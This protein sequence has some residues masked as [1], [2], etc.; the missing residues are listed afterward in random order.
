MSKA[1][2]EFRTR[3]GTD[4]REFAVWYANEDVQ[5]LIWQIYQNI[6]ADKKRH[7]LKP[8]VF[9]DN[10]EKNKDTTLDKLL[11]ACHH[12]LREHNLKFLPF[13]VKPKIL[14]HFYAGFIHINPDYIY[15]FDPVGTNIQD[16]KFR[17]CF[18]VSK[19]NQIG[20]L[21]VIASAEKIQNTTYE[22]SLVSCGPLC[23]EFLDYIMSNPELVPS[24]NMPNSIVSPQFT[25][26]MRSDFS[27]YTKSML[28]IRKKHDR[29]LGQISDA[30][31]TEPEFQEFYSELTDALLDIDADE[32][33]SID[34]IP[35]SLINGINYRTQDVQ[36]IIKQIYSSTRPDIQQ[37]FSQ[38]QVFEGETL[39][40]SEE[41]SNQHKILAQNNLKYFPFLFKPKSS[42][43]FY[44]GL[45]VR[46]P[47]YVYLFIPN[48]A[49]PANENLTTH[50]GLSSKFFIGEHPLVISPQTTSMLYH[51]NNAYTL[52]SI[53]FLE[54]IMQHEKTFEKP[55]RFS[56]FSKIHYKN[57]QIY[58]DKLIQKQRKYLVAAQSQSQ[59][60]SN[61]QPPNID[62][63]QLY[64]QYFSELAKI[65]QNA[66][67]Y[68]ESNASKELK[69]ALSETNIL[70]KELQR[71]IPIN[72]QL[73]ASTGLKDRQLLLLAD[74]CSHIACGLDFILR[75]QNPYQAHIFSY[76]H[77][78]SGVIL[79]VHYDL[80][81][82]QQY[83]QHV[84]DIAS[85]L[86]GAGWHKIK[87][88]LYILAGALLIASGIMFAASSIPL[89][90]GLLF[91]LASAAVISTGMGFFIGRDTG[92][93]G[94]V[95]NVKMHSDNTPCGGITAGK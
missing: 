62:A 60:P 8:F 58:I 48:S 13:I 70:L 56:E 87:R 75:H 12:V 40:L 11:S 25:E 54:Y 14:P 78:S 33:E 84:S 43:H 27:N 49:I 80:T 92:L 44:A 77:G 71:L 19:T 51:N 52:L 68:C 26:L 1:Q 10:M 57:P 28:A 76:K 15:I 38:P 3:D 32:N 41:L 34:A 29:Y 63:Q 23:I 18:G 81:A 16:A 36:R 22:E 31:L 88:A 17:D 5:R 24:T 20:D 95:N 74:L 45:L 90:S 30:A 82:H 66:D 55:N 72:N 47:N 42:Q 61:P 85:E 9:Y 94:A 21:R 65:V 53:E 35:C 91:T 79:Q 83:M 37:N 7:F 59:R 69:L 2:T 73:S 39:N 64:L 50:L 6:P 4:S 89:S 67:Q 93:A 46:N 86:P